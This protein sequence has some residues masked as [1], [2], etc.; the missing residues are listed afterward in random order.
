MRRMIG[1]LCRKWLAAALI[2]V[3]CLGVSVHGLQVKVYY[4]G[5]EW[6]TPKVINPGPV[7]GPPSDAIV[8]FDGT[9][10]EAW[11]G[12]ERSKIED[13]AIVVGGTLSTKQAFGDCQIH[14]EYAAP[15]PPKGKSQGRGNNGIK[16]MGR[17]EIQI[18]D[19]YENETYLDGMNGAI[20]KQ[21]PPL[22]NACRPPGE[23]QSFDIVFQAPRFED[24]KL[25]SP[26]YVTVLHNGVLIHNHVEL[27]GTTAYN[28]L[29]SYRPHAEKLPFTFAYHGSPV[30]FR[31]IWVR[32]L[33][34]LEKERKAPP[35][36]R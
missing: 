7:G 14:I 9:D 4:S 12:A 22:V 2:V 28:Q 33:R 20:Y 1:S 11:N 18:L 3:G 17:Y 24:G 35:M 23:W 16:L 27:E 36:L 10:L 21:R 5:L 25:K 29:P 6:E 34:E 32:E 13:G 15:T 30:R 19:S 26:G 31:N 8:L